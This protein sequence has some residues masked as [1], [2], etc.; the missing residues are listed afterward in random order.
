MAISQFHSSLTLGIL[1]FT[2][3]C[4]QDLNAEL[5]P[6]QL[7][8]AVYR[9]DKLAGKA[10]VSVERQGE[11]WVIRTEGSATHGLGRL[12]GVSERDL[13]EGLNV[14]GK[15]RPEY[16]SHHSRV[17]GI[18]HDWTA[19]FDWQNDIVTITKD[20]DVQPLGMGAGALDTLSLQAE[21]EHRLRD[22]NPDLQFLLADDDGLKPRTYRILAPQ[23]LETSLGCLATVP[24][25]LVIPDRKRFSRSWHARDFGFLT[26][27]L[28]RR[29]SN[30]VR[31]EMRVTG[32]VLDGKE[33]T[34]LA[35][36]A[37]KP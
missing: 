7:R 15:F 9:N 29:K 24:V 8:F 6:Y 30:G 34:P 20:H 17:A 11:R 21:L 5:R 27:R 37:G 22:R 26:V 1:L 35:P 13:A 12:L 19:R 14:D 31:L 4:A 32:M 16:F 23:Q 18:D 28:E 33:V 36:C 2:L 3:F 10:E 25:E